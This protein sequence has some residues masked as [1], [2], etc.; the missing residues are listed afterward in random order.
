MPTIVRLGADRYSAFGV[1][2]A[3][4]FED[5]PEP[6]AFFDADNRLSLCNSRFRENFPVVIESEF[7]RRYGLLADD[8]RAS[9]AVARPGDRRQGQAAPGLEQP[10]QPPAHVGNALPAV[11]CRMPG[12]GTL[13]RF[14]QSLGDEVREAQ[15]ARKLRRLTKVLRAAMAAKRQA[16]QAAKARADFFAATTHELRTPLNAIMGFSEILQKEIF[17]PLANDRYR[18]YAQIIHD[19][20]NHLLSLVNDLLDLSK[21]DAGKF[22]LHFESVLL[23]KVIV[24]CV[25][26]VETQANSSHVGISVNLYDDIRFLRGDDRRLHQ[27]LLNL[28]SNALKFTPEGGEI[29]ISA[30]R[31]G[32][33]IAIEVSD[34]GIGIAPE[35]I[36]KVLE[37]FGQVDSARGRKFAGTGLG[38]PLTKELAEL[39]GGSLSIESTPDIG[40]RVTLLLPSEDEPGASRT[41][42]RN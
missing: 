29:H 41:G 33:C 32:D 26:G 23:L 20:G 36:P 8:R 31:R 34:S 25:R 17:G 1:D 39:H 35:E 18:E 6:L 15:S 7:V 24:D 13:L 5:W 9:R 19:S 2:L 14:R 38:L 42:R 3:C 16:Q 37:P 21:L 22:D 27:M 30:F 11:I 4:L 40:T 10:V 28:L 12:G